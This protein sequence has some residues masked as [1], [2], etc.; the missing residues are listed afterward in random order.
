MIEIQKEIKI[1]IR[2]DKNLSLEDREKT[3]GKYNDH[4]WRIYDFRLT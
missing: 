4:Y 1:E 2:T 3:P